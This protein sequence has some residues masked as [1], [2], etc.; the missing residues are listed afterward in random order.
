M[1]KRIR[2]QAG[3]AAIRSARHLVGTAALL[4]SLLIT[5]APASAG[6]VVKEWNQIALAATVTAGQGPVPQTRTM[7]I[8]QVSVH[9]SIN[10]ITRRYKTYLSTSRAPWGASPEAAAIAAAHYALVHLFPA[11]GQHFEPGARRFARRAR[12]DRRRPGRQRRRERGGGDS[13][14]S[15]DRR[16]RAGEVPLYRAWRRHARVCGWPSVLPRSCCRAGETSPRGYYEADHSFGPMVLRRF[17]A[18]VTPA[19]TT[20]SGSWD[21]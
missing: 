9:D 21:P 14:G 2:I 15:F 18:G 1:S 8:V 6:D 3:Q 11:S 13:F 12:I 19:T 16:R 20:R 7:A 17:S 4:S 5:S 10:A